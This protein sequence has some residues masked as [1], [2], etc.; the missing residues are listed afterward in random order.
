[1]HD[2][3]NRGLVTCRAEFRGSWTHT[4]VKRPTFSLINNL[5]VRTRTKKKKHKAQ[6]WVGP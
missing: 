3:E 6:F 5:N 4:A 2:I 1:M